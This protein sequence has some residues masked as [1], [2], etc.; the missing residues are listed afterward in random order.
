MVNPIKYFLYFFQILVIIVLVIARAGFEGET[1]LHLTNPEWVSITSFCSYAFIYPILI[2]TYITGQAVPLITVSK[3][4]QS[5]K[6][7]LRLANSQETSIK[8]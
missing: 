4:N 6:S 5:V 1:F 8:W 3:V 2:I 7:R